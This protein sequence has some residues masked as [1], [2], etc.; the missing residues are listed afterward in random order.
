MKKRLRYLKDLHKLNKRQFAIKCGLKETTVANYLYGSSV[1]S[2]E[3]T[4]QIAK[5]FGVKPAW[6]AGWDVTNGKVVEKKVYIRDSSAR[7][8]P[9]WENDECGKLI[10]WTKRGKPVD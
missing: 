10:R 5:A 2:L 9:D 4:E 7:I 1:P 3:I 6:L 8:P